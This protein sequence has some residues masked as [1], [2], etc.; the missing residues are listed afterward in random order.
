MIREKCFIDPMRSYNGHLTLL[1]NHLRV[2]V[3]HTVDNLI[4]FF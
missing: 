1:Q 4:N 3:K 2:Y